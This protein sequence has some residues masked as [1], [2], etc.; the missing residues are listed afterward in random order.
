MLFRSDQ[1]RLQVA[2]R[3]DERTFARLLTRWPDQTAIASQPLASFR[4]ACTAARALTRVGASDEQRIVIIVDE[5]TYLY[6]LLRREH[7]A[8]AD[9]AQLRD[10]MRQW[11]SLLESKTFSA[12]V[13]GQDTMP[14]F[15]QAF[16]NEFS[17]M[18]KIGRAHV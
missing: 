9:Q 1:L 14:Y 6:E 15:L 2:A 5:F 12:L 3:L 11:K 17:V 4:R 8:P 7:V 16:P 13:V 10:F 18:H